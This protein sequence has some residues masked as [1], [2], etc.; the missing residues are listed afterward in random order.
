MVDDYRIVSTVSPIGQAIVG[1]KVG[2]TYTFEKPTGEIAS[3]MILEVEN[4][5]TNTNEKQKHL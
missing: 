1:K 4:V 2:E 3:G 5:K